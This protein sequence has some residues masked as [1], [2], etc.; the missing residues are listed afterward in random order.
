V[1]AFTILFPLTF[2][3][4]AMSD[5]AM[6]CS[7][8][9]GGNPNQP[10]QC[11][12]VGNP[13]NVMTGN[14]YQRE[15]DMP[16]LPGVLGLELVRHYNSAFSGPDHP[17]G[18]FGRGWRLS[19][20]IE[21][22]D[23]WGKIQVLLADGGRVIFDRDRRSP[24]GCSTPYPANGSMTVGRQQNGQLDYTWT[25][26]D[27]RKLH[28]NAAGKLDR[29]TAATGEIARLLYDSQNVLVRVIDPQGRSLNLAYYDRHIPN[30][31][32]GVQFID[33]PVGR[34]AYEYGSIVPKGTALVDQRPLLANLARVRL[35]DHFDPY[36]KAHSLSSR[37]TTR[38]T[39]SRIYHYEDPRSPWLMTGISI[40]AADEDG[41]PVTTRYATYGYDDT[42]RAILS[43]HA[44]NVGKVTL[45][46]H[47]AGKTVL[48]NSLGQKTVYRYTV[49]A[50]EY[51]L[52]EVRGAGCALCGEPNLRYG[53]DNAGR[54]N[55]TTKLSE[56]GEPV[57]ATRSEHD[58]LGRVTRIGRF[59]YQRGKPQP[60]QLQVRFGYQGARF[61]PTMMAR[62]S[63]V[64]GKELVTLIDYNEVGQPLSV[65][66]TGWAP[67]VD[68]KHAAERIERT[69]RYRYA[70]I[71]GRSLL[72]EIDGPLPNGRTSSP[73]DSDITVIEYDHHSR[74]A[75]TPK[76]SSGRDEL[77]NYSLSERREGLLT[78]IIKP[79]N[80]RNEISYD[81]AG[82]IVAVKD[83]EGH[84]SSLRYS[85]RGQLLAI[86]RDG[87]TRS[88]RYDALDN[89]IESGYGDES[90]Y[91]ALARNGYD[92]AGRN[93][94][95]ASPLGIVA[96]RRLDTEGQ[97]LESSTLSSTI[98]QVQY[99]EYDQPGRLHGVTD[100][101]GRGRRIGWNASGLPD[102][103]TDALG[104]TVRFG[105]DASRNV[106]AVTEAD[107]STTRFE[108]DVYGRPTAVIAPTGAKT[109]YIRDDF[110]R[111]L[112]TISADSGT[113]TRR[114]DAVD[115]LVAS[116]DANGNRSIYKYDVM[117]RIVLQ[118]VTDVGND[119]KE[120]VTTWR[121]LGPHLVAVDHPNQAER[122][123]YDILGRNV[124]KTVILKLS[125]GAH[126][127][128]TTHYR[129]DAMGRLAGVSLP[130][131]SM[132]EYRRN[133]Q[134][135][136]TALDRIPA[137]R[138][139]LRW[140]LPQQ[141]IIQ[142][143]ERDIVGIKRLTYGNGIEAYYQRSKEGNLARIVY[144][145]LRMQGPHEQY[146]AAL[147]ALLGVLPASAASAPAATLRAGQ[148]NM[149]GALSLRA[150][151]AA[152]LDH[153]Y[154]WDA[155]GN[156]LYIR[157][158]NAASSYAYDARDRL[159]AAAT[160]PDGRFARYHYDGN[161]NRV[162]AQDGL[163]DQSDLQGNT[164]K[165]SYMQS[166]DRWQTD[167]NS[168]GSLDARYDAAGQPERIG[169]LGFVWD[170]FGK[171]RE[172]RDG[173]ES[174]A[175]YRY[176]HRG[177]RIEKIVGPQHTYYLYEDRK[178]VAELD[179]NGALRREYVYLADKPVVVIDKL[180]GSNN[181]GPS[182]MKLKNNI[183]ATWR[184]LF[185]PSET[186]V[187]LQI[188]HL[189]A[190]E[191]ATDAKG[192]PVLQMTYS[193]FGGLMQ[194]ITKG[195][196]GLQLNLRLPGQYADRE[197][198]LYYNDH[199]YYDP[200]RGRYLTPDPMGLGGGANNYAYVNGNPLKYFD[201]EG[202]TLFAFDGTGNTNDQTWLAANGSS[203]SNI[204]QFRQLYGDGNRRYITGVGTVHYDQQYGDIVPATY[205]PTGI[206]LSAPQAD[207]GANYSG[208]A[209]IQR[210][211]QYFNDE[212]DLAADDGPM[213]VD[214]IG[215]SRGAAE[216]RDFANRVIANTTNGWYAYKNINGQQLC[217]KVNFRFMGLFDTVLSTNYSGNSYNLA[218]SLQFNYVAQAVALNEH[219][220]KT[221]RRLLD[222]VGAFPLES[223]MGGSSPIGKK[224]IER[225]FIGSHA[226]I[227]GGFD[228][229]ESQLSQVALAW[230]VNQAKAAGI[231]MTDSPLLHTIVANPV[232]HDKS[233]NQY[234][235]NSAPI[236]PGIE[237]RTVNYRDGRRT[238]QMAMTGANMTW[239][240]TQKFVSYLPAIRLGDRG[241]MVRFPSGDYVTGTVDM[242]RYL[243]W[244]NKNGY[245][246]NLT[247]N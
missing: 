232:L 122:Y 153:R 18:P 205:K 17:N 97:L 235:T 103:L 50:G 40:E 101:V 21:V 160:G 202:L 88:T 238:T 155:Q 73:L 211:L 114:F 62:P 184:T 131:G 197:T 108:L 12:G 199:R 145:T 64:P 240:D 185:G 34:F 92:D 170:A 27:G 35:P 124:T 195:T 48:T 95:T 37:G 6:S 230:M 143:I 66:E 55:E 70:T 26:T 182:E 23:R 42:G 159:I 86:V 157:D 242:R 168:A 1:A 180:N 33:T 74:S 152:L 84:T 100:A 56:S 68:G 67:T 102:E 222:S 177:E 237:D 137:G 214:I 107:N 229:N 121:Y 111:T 89:P 244:L 183:A 139:W 217:Q 201:P 78:A 32:H 77:A 20:E 19:Y 164:V 120:T 174:V 10:S 128:T 44:N 133:G 113:T 13:I 149:P 135:Q 25:W 144:R 63:V 110:G 140:L 94:W 194:T 8:N 150:D 38:S 198:G 175:R 196:P 208:P 54:L 215:F 247:I 181:D 134:N 118:S 5:P 83:T 31:Y 147:G 125:S 30:Q 219:R 93:I 45:D 29:I 227:G 58:K 233:D 136:I 173:K 176:N 246:I 151:P 138:T 163:A 82:R 158:K 80:R 241:Q 224:R 4:P 36:T 49:I 41:K 239:A 75:P 60:V 51:R 213:D 130:D 127:S 223:I 53:Y 85:P 96:T 52:L 216:A 43:T 192:K 188:N 16:G 167:E 47:E 126:V 72:T 61:A 109:R 166:V 9:P 39:T 142:D 186:I 24:T 69:V 81:Y 189:G 221:T 11:A 117:G 191:M 15:D 129:Y 161:G 46:N 209:R 112:M 91:Q 225:G 243:E 228:Q 2:S 106:T 172:V 207:M 210:M 220:G 234:S 245:D 141:T 226:D 165:T 105:Y 146:G 99:Y 132:L 187:Y 90:H 116:T 193:P 65:T 22:T 179:S 190:V 3:T 104:R 171:L 154:L 79:G 115:Q 87:I 162:L 206:P 98:K 57:A 7:A 59:F 203:L 200:A 28:F 231:R 169:K 14:K 76:T 148:S 71:N 236:A 156:L 204:W 178:L 218:I 119:A 123:D 212:A